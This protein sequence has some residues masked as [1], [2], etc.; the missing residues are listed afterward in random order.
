MGRPRQVSDEDILRTARTMFIQQGPQTPTTA[1]A[2]ALGISQP[3]LFKRF[4]SK[5]ELM[6]AALA[7][8]A[9]PD[10]IP[11]LENGPDNRPLRTQMH[12]IGTALVR[13]MKEAAPALMVLRA[14]GIEP[15][16]LLAC[17]EQGPPPLVAMRHL[18]AWFTRAQVQGLVREDTSP[19]SA[20]LTY[21][22]AIQFPVFM[23]H[24]LRQV[25]KRGLPSLDMNT[26]LEQVVTMLGRS[27]EPTP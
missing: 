20:A 21:F 22:G 10:W 12:E 6:L 17:Y 7:P 24:M 25:V 2:N 14:S 3:A 19:Q 9:D 11:L 1:I 4:G 15:E 27:L 5:E 8:P 18:T 13:F 26:H 23:D 16:T